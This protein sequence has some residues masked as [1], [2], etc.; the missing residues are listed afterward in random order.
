MRLTKR[1]AALPGLLLAL[2]HAPAAAAQEGPGLRSNAA[3]ITLNGRVQT[4]FNTTTAEGEPEGL[5]LLRRVR[6]EARVV[7]NDLIS[8]KIQPDFAGNRVSVKDAYIA[9]RPSEGVEIVAGNAHRPFSYLTR[10][11]S[12]RM[13]P[14]EKGLEIRGVDGWDEQTLV[15]ELDYAN[16]D[17]GVQ[18][19][20]TPESA[21]LGLNAAFALLDGPL[22]GEV[23]GRQTFQVVSRVAME[24]IESLILTAAWSRR[25]FPDAG[26][27]TGGET[28][29]EAGNALL[30]S[31]G[32]DPPAGLYLLGEITR[33]DFDPSRDVRF[34]GA[35]L[36]SGYRIPFPGR[37]TMV[38][39]VVRV[40]HGRVTD[41]TVKDGTLMT[42]GVNVY[43][44]ALNRL[45]LDYD[46]WRP[47]STGENA[48]SF[49]A[50]VQ[51]AF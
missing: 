36:W 28:S 4:Q 44:G 51:L 25:H 46:A 14:I 18:L 3:E 37:V 49:K 43:F 15:D 42:A 38:E 35:G 41:A 8:G 50:M 16:R 12:L 23:V 7:V 6:L 29:L 21:P 47:G 34:E 9:F 1:Q 11:S 22:G 20:L 48:G 13:A 10:Y 17:V 5:W 30:A 33:G 39:P 2:A 26:E 32:W 31:A 24:P 27:I 40:S 19:L 45:M